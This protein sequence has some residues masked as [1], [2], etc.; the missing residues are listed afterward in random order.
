MEKAEKNGSKSGEIVPLPFNLTKDDIRVE[1]V[2]TVK[3]K[4]DLLT[5]SLTHVVFVKE[6][7]VIRL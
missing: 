1:V 3:I 5:I 2:E 6:Y 4:K 7:L